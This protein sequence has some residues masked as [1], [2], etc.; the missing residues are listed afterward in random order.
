MADVVRPAQGRDDPQLVS[1]RLPRR[2]W[3]GRRLPLHFVPIPD[4]PFATLEHVLQILV[5]QRAYCNLNAAVEGHAVV[6][7]ERPLALVSCLSRTIS[8]LALPWDDD[9]ETRRAE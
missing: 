6:L 2:G 8:L 7:G 1:G 9:Q 5:V 4:A 3:P